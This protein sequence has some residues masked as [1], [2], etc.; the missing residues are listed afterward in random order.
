MRSKLFLVL[1]L[2]VLL[3]SASARAAEEPGWTSL[4]DGKSLD[5]WKESGAKG[6]FY[7]EDGKIVAKGSSGLTASW[8]AD[9]TKFLGTQGDLNAPCDGKGKRSFAG[10]FTKTNPFDKTE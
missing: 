8:S 3:S 5:G 4:F 10:R 9:G 1:G 6:S 7:V 2:S